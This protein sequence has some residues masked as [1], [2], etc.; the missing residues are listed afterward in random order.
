MMMST[1]FLSLF[2]LFLLLQHHTTTGQYTID[3]SSGTGPKFDGIGG[4]SGGGV[5]DELLLF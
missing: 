3:D 4:L 5:R 2:A 1:N